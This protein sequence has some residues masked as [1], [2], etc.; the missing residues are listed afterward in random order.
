MRL[1]TEKIGPG[2][3]AIQFD[4][5]SVGEA[6]KIGGQYRIE[7]IDGTSEYSR[8]TGGVIDKASDWVTDQVLKAGEAKA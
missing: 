7:Y 2:Q 1:I 3:Y 8:N 5:H 4:G 6:H